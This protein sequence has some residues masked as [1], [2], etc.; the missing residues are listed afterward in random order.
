M[1]FAVIAAAGKM[2][3]AW[4][5]LPWTAGEALHAAERLFEEWLKKRGSVGPLEIERAI[6]QL[7]ATLERDGASRFTP[8]DDPDKTIINRLGFVQNDETG[9]AQRYYVLPEAWKEINRGHDA[10]SVAKELAKRGAIRPDSEGKFQTKYRLPNLGNRR[11][12][13]IESDLLFDDGDNK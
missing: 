6:S 13:V 8:W 11:C 1:R 2:A 3:T 12:Y 4:K 9:G 5:A 10:A 7:R